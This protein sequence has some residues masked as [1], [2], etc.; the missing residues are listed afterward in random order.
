MNK[1]FSTLVATAL[2]ACGMSVGAQA[3]ATPYKVLGS[4]DLKDGFV[5]LRSASGDN[6]LVVKNGKLDSTVVAAT[7]STFARLDSMA[8]K[9]TVKTTTIGKSFQLQNRKTG[10]I[11]SYKKETG[12]VTLGGDIKE[13]GLD[14]TGFYAMSGDSTYYLKAGADFAGVVEENTTTTFANVDF[15]KPYEIT[16]SFNLTAEDFNDVVKKFS[17]AAVNGRKDPAKTT[18]G[19]KN[20]LT[21]NEWVAISIHGKKNADGTLNGQYFPQLD[22]TTPLDTLLFQ[23]VGAKDSTG[24]LYVD[25][26]N[27]TPTQSMKLAVADSAF[28][29]RAAGTASPSNYYK[30]GLDSLHMFVVSYD[31]V[32]DSMSIKPVATP[33]KL[34]APNTDGASWWN[35]DGQE[36]VKTQLGVASTGSTEAVVCL[37]AL[38]N[39]TV[40]AVDSITMIDAE[41]T[42][43]SYANIK[44]PLRS[45]TLGGDAKIATDKVYFI[46]Y[47]NKGDNKDKYVVA[48]AVVAANGKAYEDK[49]YASMPSTQ[50]VVKAGT[51][52][53]LYEIMNR[54][55]TS[56]KYSG[57][58]NKVKGADGKD[59]ADTYVNGTD[60]LLLE[61]AKCATLEGKITVNNKNYATTGYGYYDPKV[62]NN[63]TYKVASA[64]PFMKDLFMQAKKDSTIT[65][66]EDDYYFYLKEIDKAAYGATVKGVDSLYRYTY[67]LVT[68][69]DEFVSRDNNKYILTKDA[70]KKPSVFFFKSWGAADNYMLID[71]TGIGAATV[72][73]SQSIIVSVNAQNAEIYP[74]ALTD[75]KSDLFT[76]TEKAT[77]SMLFTNP[78]HYNIYNNNDRLAVGKNNLAVM[79]QPGNDLKA[80]ADKFVNDNFTLWFD[81]VNYKADITASYFISQ[82]IKAAAGEETKAE[83][84]S[85]ERLYLTVASQDSIDKSDDLAKLYTLDD[86]ARLYFRTAARHGVDTLIVNNFDEKAGVMAPDT[87][88]AGA[89][90]TKHS[91]DAAKGLLLGG[92]D[93]FKFQFE[94]IDGTDNYVM[95]SLTNKYVVSVNGLLVVKSDSDENMIA[96]LKAPDYATSNE[97]V[98]VSE[99]TV[100]ATEGGVQI[101]GAAG[102][103][104]VI[105]NILGQVVA[106]TV[107]TS[108]NAV[109]AAPQGVVVVAVEGEEAVKAIVK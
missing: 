99:V 5:Y 74:S 56:I 51:A 11:L 90:G 76:V 35:A 94:V 106:N 70:T 9:V 28:F 12:A 31:Y 75:A 107:L 93:N 45:S 49:A 103:K 25:T 108:D 3:A 22:N 69:K 80:D 60:T 47:A 14:N 37:R 105:S 21:E 38:D 96:S 62:L 92:I 64:S 81:T 97:D 13:W 63:K 10:D 33:I 42:G 59:I 100:I 48:N 83:E 17:F 32:T 1:R 67:K 27:I 55:F 24:F 109:I 41:N 84:A 102:K 8:W 61:D 79:A 78:T 30:A 85:A 46:K 36:N 72:D 18:D 23:K 95:K 50:W 43:L 39:V 15:V 6:S 57:A 91:A 44:S 101:A 2:V 20:V 19:Q 4:S 40:L 104:V 82:G 88:A 58:F 29:R 87:V 68:K 34:S 71:T 89:D 16:T 52:D 54:E 53:G 77:P 73:W 86:A 7:D 65:L 26:A 98:A 66:A